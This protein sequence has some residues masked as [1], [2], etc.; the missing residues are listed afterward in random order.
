[1]TR[2]WNVFDPLPAGGTDRE[3]AARRAQDTTLALGPHAAGLLRERLAAEG[4]SYRPGDSFDL[5]A[6]REGRKAILAE[7]L[8]ELDQA[9]SSNPGT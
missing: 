5:A 4:A 8:A 1:M 6:W 3:T 2:S 7:L 9:R